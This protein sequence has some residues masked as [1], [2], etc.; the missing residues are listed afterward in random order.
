MFKCL[1]MELRLEEKSPWRQMLAVQL[2]VVIETLGGSEISRRHRDSFP[3]KKIQ[4]FKKE[5]RKK[6]S[7][8]K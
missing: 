6:R 4:H 8:Q 1:L 2:H 3:K 7:L 5:Q